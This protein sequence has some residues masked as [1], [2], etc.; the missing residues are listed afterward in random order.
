[1]NVQ[2]AALP[3]FPSL[4]LWPQHDYS[5]SRTNHIPNPFPPPPLRVPDG[6]D[7]GLQP[8]PRPSHQAS[9]TIIDLTSDDSDP[10]PAPPTHHRNAARPPRFGREDIIDLTSLP[11]LHSPSGGPIDLTN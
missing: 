1:M 6:M 2:M 10:P 4:T 3:I 5:A 11:D 9:Q 8:R 7:S